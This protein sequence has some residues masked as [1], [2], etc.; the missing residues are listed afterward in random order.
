MIRT[1]GLLALLAALAGCT[2]Y[3]DRDAPIASVAVFDPA[4][5]TGLWY[6]IARFPVVFQRGCTATT[7]EYGLR[8]DGALSVVNTCR[9][10]SP[11]GPVSQIEGEARVVGPGQLEVSFDGV[12]FGGAPYWVLWVDEDYQTAVDGVPSGR[13]GWILN[14]AP[15]ISA[16][17]L[18]AAQRVL[19]F[20]GYDLSRLEM[21]EHAE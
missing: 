13:E 4:R 6:E 9:E 15:T 17:R 2:T 8:E 14:R 7:A 16:D 1:L 5:Y 10:G 11:D 18:E 12:P 19:A 20:N 3:R 21:T